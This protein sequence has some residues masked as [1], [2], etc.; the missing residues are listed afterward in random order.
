MQSEYSFCSTVE[1]FGITSKILIRIFSE[2][3]VFC[4]AGYSNYM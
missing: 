2:K 1:V 3:K 4:V